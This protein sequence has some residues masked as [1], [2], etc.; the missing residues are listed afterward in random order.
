[1]SEAPPNARGFLL[2]LIQANISLIFRV[3]GAPM[4]IWVGN[5]IPAQKVSVLFKPKYPS[6]KCY[7][8]KIA[9]EWQHLPRDYTIRK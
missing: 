7:A 1:M 9:I 6:K 2:F 4:L 3:F 5:R 8:A